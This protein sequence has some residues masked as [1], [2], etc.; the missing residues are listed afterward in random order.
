LTPIRQIGSP[1]TLATEYF[2]VVGL[3]N[4]STQ[5]VKF[6]EQ[7]VVFSDGGCPPDC[8]YK[9]AK[10]GTQQ[11]IMWESSIAKAKKRLLEVFRTV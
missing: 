9:P 1:L 6:I 4:P 10:N 11:A 3:F 8:V 2:G 7:R 5:E